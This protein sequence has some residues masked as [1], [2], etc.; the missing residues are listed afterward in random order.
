MIYQLIEI[1]RLIIDRPSNPKIDHLVTFNNGNIK[2]NYSNNDYTLSLAVWY[3]TKF[4]SQ[5]L[6]TNFGNHLHLA[7]KIGSQCYF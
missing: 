3:K 5:N 4:G 2:L 6:A 7:T 1:A